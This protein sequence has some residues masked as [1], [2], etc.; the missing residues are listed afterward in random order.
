[1]SPY[2]VGDEVMSL[3]S[4]QPLTKELE[5]PYVVS[6]FLK[7]LRLTSAAALVADALGSQ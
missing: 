6:Y 4:F 3:K 1:M 5:T 2:R 7:E